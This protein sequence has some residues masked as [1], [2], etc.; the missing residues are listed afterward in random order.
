M[1][2]VIPEGLKDFEPLTLSNQNRYLAVVEAELTKK[3]QRNFAL[4]SMQT[5]FPA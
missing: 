5:K 4:D 2:Q 1:D 3:E